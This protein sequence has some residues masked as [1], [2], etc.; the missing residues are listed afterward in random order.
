MMDQTD[1]KKYNNTK[2]VLGLTSTLLGWIFLWII[3]QTG[4]TG[5]AESLAFSQVS[6]PYLALLIFCTLIGIIETLL[7]FPLG[8]YNDY[9]LEH[10]YELS[11][12]TLK[13]YF[14][15]KGKGLLVGLVIGVPVVLVFYY[16]LRR[17]ETDWWLP[18]GIFMFLLSVVLGRLAPT[19][20][21]PLFYK[22]ILIEN[23]EVKNRII[24]RCEEAG[25]KVEGVYQFDMSKSTKKANAAFTGLGKSKRV[26]IGDTLLDNFELDEIDA[27]LAH[28][29]GHFKLKH[30]W[31]MMSLGTVITFAGLYLVSVLYSG[32]ID[33][34]GFTSISQLAALPLLGLLFGIYGFVSGPIQNIISRNHERDADKFSVEMLEN[35][36][37]MVSA[38]EKLA[39][40]NLADREPHPMV[41]FLFHSHPSIKNRIDELNKL[42]A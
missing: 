35:S 23:E 39:D 17:Y 21:F 25:M 22:F 13:S 38:L 42:S 7:F 2:L 3:V 20:I 31:K 15:E 11:N 26:I 32:W 12:H 8:F 30:I 19:I 40:Q 24:E 5:Y 37:N 6:S 16:L 9:I 41:E 28:E 14:W 36:G 1:A 4:F 33:E 27:V 34:F 18:V 10:K 29:L